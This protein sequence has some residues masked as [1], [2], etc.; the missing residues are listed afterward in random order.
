MRDGAARLQ[1]AAAGDDLQCQLQQSG[2]QRIASLSNVRTAIS[3]QRS[4]NTT[5]FRPWIEAASADRAP[6][7]RRPPNQPRSAPAGKVAI[8]QES[9]H[10]RCVYLARDCLMLHRSRAGA[11]AASR[12]S[13]RGV[14]PFEAGGREGGQQLGKRARRAQRSQH[15]AH[16][17]EGVRRFPVMTADELPSACSLAWRLHRTPW[18]AARKSFRSTFCDKEHESVSVRWQARPR[19]VRRGR[20]ATSDKPR[21][22]SVQAPPRCS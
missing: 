4:K 5:A 11:I 13:G 20:P 15:R 16:C 22:S 6:A 17:R 19:C 18:N 10:E 7:R 3:T 14:D 21:A 9:W 12:H 2:L 1:G 8:N